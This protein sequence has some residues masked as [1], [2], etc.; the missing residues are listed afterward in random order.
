MFPQ[1]RNFYMLFASAVM[2]VVCCVFV[3]VFLTPPTTLVRLAAMYDDGVTRLT[4]GSW[5]VMRAE[6][7]Y[8]DAIPAAAI[9]N[10]RIKSTA[11]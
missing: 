7:R 9:H 4:S 2:C 3:C 5:P 6:P 10:H 11:E 1:K 8:D